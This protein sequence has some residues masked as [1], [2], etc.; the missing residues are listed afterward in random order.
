MDKLCV[1]VGTLDDIGGVLSLLFEVAPEIPLHVDNQERRDAVSQMVHDTIAEAISWVATDTLDDIV[2]FILAVRD[3]YER[4][5][6]DDGLIELKYI[7]VSE[8]ERGR[9][10]CSL[11]IAQMKAA[12][13]PLTA[14]VKNDNKSGMAARLEHSGFQFWA[15]S[16]VSC[17]R[18]FKWSPKEAAN[19]PS[20]A[21]VPSR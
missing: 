15:D 21:T 8:R 16:P 12:K 10:V 7:G 9:G 3:R 20:S 4:F 1:R 2:G 13:V 6:N 17:E 19:T 18:K 11:L 14:T 5:Q